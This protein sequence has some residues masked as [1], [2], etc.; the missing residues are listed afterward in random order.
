MI[1]NFLIYKNII[2]NKKF[3]IKFYFLFINLLK[4]LI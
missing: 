1:V 4:Y 3:N 2:N